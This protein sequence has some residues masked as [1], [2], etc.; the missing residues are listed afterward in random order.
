MGSIKYSELARLYGEHAKVVEEAY[1]A[2]ENSVNEM[3]NSLRKATARVIGSDVL[4]KVTGFSKNR[5]RYWEIQKSEVPH[6]W[7]WANDPS[8][9]HP[10]QLVLHAWAGQR[11]PE[12]AVRRVVALKNRD[13]LGPFVDLGIPG[14]LF[15]V[16]IE[17]GEGQ[18]MDAIAA[19][20]ANLLQA[21]RDAGAAS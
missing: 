3:L 10:G 4:Q 14:A 11:P 16:P 20:V 2:F 5:Y 9:I 18:D 12:E 21:L 19:R 6:I 8:I 13:D 15:S 1:S 7:F 17:S